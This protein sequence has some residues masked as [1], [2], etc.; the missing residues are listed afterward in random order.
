MRHTTKILLFLILF[1]SGAAFSQ[2]TTII[3]P[4]YAIKFR[5]FSMVNID[6]TI[7]AQVEFFSSPNNSLQ[8]SYG[9]GSN[10]LFKKSRNEFAHQ[11]RLELKKY[12]KTIDMHNPWGGYFAGELVYKKVHQNEI[13]TYLLDENISNPKTDEYI[14]NVNVWALHLKYGQ[15]YIMKGVPV[16]DAFIGIGT[17]YHYNYDQ[18][19]KAGYAF[20]YY[21]SYNRLAGKGF[22]PSFTI[23]VG[24]GMNRWK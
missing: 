8:I 17:R 5:P 3:L 1:L 23:G 19:L 12:Y 4:K 18:G 21:S 7:Q 20:T 10:R 14:V 24:I 13:A 6:P 15:T 11:I 16:L 9:Y 2:D 22:H